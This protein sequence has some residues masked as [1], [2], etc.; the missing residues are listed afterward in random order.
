M[1]CPEAELYVCQ[2]EVSLRELPIGLPQ[3]GRFPD[4]V[5]NIVSIAGIAIIVII[6]LM[7]LFNMR[8]KKGGDID[9]QKLEKKLRK[10]RRKIPR[11]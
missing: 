5:S 3:H 10:R 2:D 9:K 11:R 1:L 6:F 4:L 8:S 7:M